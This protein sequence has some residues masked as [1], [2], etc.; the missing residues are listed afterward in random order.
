MGRV[1]ERSLRKAKIGHGLSCPAGGKEH[2]QEWLCHK[3]GVLLPKRGGA[4]STAF[5]IFLLDFPA[6]SGWAN[7]WRAY[8]AYSVQ[9]FLICEEYYDFRE[10]GRRWRRC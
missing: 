1:A 8:G 5:A 10:E 2:S 9:L 6:L 4:A 3:K 7:V